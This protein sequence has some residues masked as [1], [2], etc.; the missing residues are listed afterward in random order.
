MASNIDKKKHAEQ[1]EDLQKSKGLNTFLWLLSMVIIAVAAVGNIY[2]AD[3]FSTPIR[4]VAVVI[5]LLIALGI[6]AITNQGTKARAFLKDSRIELRKIVW[7]TRSEAMQ[8]TLIVM[9]VTMIVSLI[10]WGLDSIIVSVIN[11]LTNLRF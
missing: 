9:A 10:L 5:L 6:L 2:F 4:V 11:F 3:Q 1:A 7:P 8:T